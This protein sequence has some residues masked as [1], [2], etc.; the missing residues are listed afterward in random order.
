MTSGIFSLAG[1]TAIVTGASRGIGPANA[2]LYAAAG[3]RVVIAS[4]KLEACAVVADGINAAHGPG[5][6]LALACNIGRKADLQ[7]LVDQTEAAFGQVD[8]LVANAAINPVAG[9]LADYSDDAW[10]KI[11]GTNLRST[12]Q[13]C[14]MVLPGMVA[15]REGAVIVLSSITALRGNGFIGAYGVSKA[16]EAALVRNLAVEHGP[17]NVRVNAIAPGVIQTVFARE[18]VENP[19]I[20]AATARRVPARRFGLPQDIAG[21]ALLLA[22]QAGAYINGQTIV[23]DGGATIS[24]P[25]II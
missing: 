6:A 22:S 24:D 23:V 11:M 15:R 20:A 5:R 21:V 4:R 7:A 8:I 18:L 9:P 19:E 14:N 16:G 25:T 12:W 13:L 2:E 10:D 17:A 3:A 1:R